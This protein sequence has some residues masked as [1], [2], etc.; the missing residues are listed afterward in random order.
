M[1]SCKIIFSDRISP[2]NYLA[3]VISLLHDPAPALLIAAFEGGAVL[4]GRHQHLPSALRVDRCAERSLP[5]LR[6]LTGGRSL[7]IGDGVLAVVLLLPNPSA[8][9]SETISPAKV[10]NRYVRGIMAGLARFGLSPLYGGDDF[11]LINKKIGGYLSS[12]TTSEGTTL[13]EA[14]LALEEGMILPEELSAYPPH[15]RPIRSLTTLAAESRRPLTMESCVEALAEGFKKKYR[16]EMEE[17]RLEAGKAE[18]LPAIEPL[19]PLPFSRREVPI[20]FLE[21]HVA[22]NGGMISECRIMGDFIAPSRTITL[23]ERSLV[24]SPLDRGELTA[25]VGSFFFDPSHFMMGIRPVPMIPDA[26]LE[27]AGR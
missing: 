11:L 23:L 26:I 3:S 19:P 13:F 24:G 16:L 25:R 1:R 18:P 12:E 8:L 27:A 15:S 21:A 22:L 5:I 14:F 6:R 4:L 9:L 17:R 20:G 10:I 7:L 2:Y